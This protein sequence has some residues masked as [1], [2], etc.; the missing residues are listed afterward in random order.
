MGEPALGHEIEHIRAPILHGDVLNFRAFHGNQLNYGAVQGRGVE[1]GS[2]AAF[3]VS[4]FGAFID[5][6]E[7]A[8]ELSE[9]FGVDA[10]VSLERVL[11]FHARRNVNERAAAED[12]GVERGEFVVA[13]RDDLAEPLPENLRVLLQSFGRSNED[14]ALFA[15]CFL[16]V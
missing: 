14:N 13:G 7:C 16:D 8:L 9:I 11:H 1:L 12:R 6:D 3:H 10:E 4:K 5:N 15:D 2:G